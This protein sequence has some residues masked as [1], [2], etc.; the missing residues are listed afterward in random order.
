MTCISY[1]ST[2]QYF[3]VMGQI[4]NQKTFSNEKTK[5]IYLKEGKGKGK[6]N[7]DNCMKFVSR[8]GHH[9]IV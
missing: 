2:A 1:S 8:T 7:T 5:E 6:E 3:E 9:R 4:N